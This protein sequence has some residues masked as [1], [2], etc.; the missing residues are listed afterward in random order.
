MDKSFQFGVVTS[1]VGEF[2][3]NGIVGLARSDSSQS[4]VN[5][6]WE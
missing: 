1:I 5:A 2:E 3:A 6:L 4:F